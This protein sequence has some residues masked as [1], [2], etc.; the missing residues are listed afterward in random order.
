MGFTIFLFIC[1]LIV[2]IIM[3]IGGF[4]LKYK[5]PKEINSVVGY[6]TPRSQKNIETWMF[7]NKYCGKLWIRLGLIVLILSAI[8]QILFIYSSYEYF[9]IVAMYIE[10]V[11]V[12]VIVISIIPVE[13]ALKRN[14][15]DDGVKK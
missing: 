9:G 14:F 15:D 5:T 12:A 8:I 11:Q 7:A 13:K 2:P 6:R 1:S 10:A 3:L 4:L